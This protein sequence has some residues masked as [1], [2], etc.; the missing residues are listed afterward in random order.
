LATGLEVY[1]VAVVTDKDYLALVVLESSGTCCD[2]GGEL[3][4]VGTVVGAYED[5]DVVVLVCV[6]CRGSRGKGERASSSATISV[7]VWFFCM[8]GPKR[9]SRQ[10]LLGETLA[11][12]AM[13]F[14]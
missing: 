6:E 7:G 3:F 2:S 4:A 8:K 11:S 14:G 1:K 5:G 12:W 10:S 13:M 9:V